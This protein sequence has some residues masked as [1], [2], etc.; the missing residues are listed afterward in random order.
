MPITAQGM[1]Q[2]DLDTFLRAI[3]TLQ[4]ELRTDRST[5]KASQRALLV[6]LDADTG[7]TDTDYEATLMIG[8]TGAAWPADPSSAALV[9]SGFTSIDMSQDDLNTFVQAFEDLINELQTDRATQ[10]LSWTALVQK[11]DADGGI[12]STDYEAKYG[13]GGSVKPWPAN[14]A[15]SAIDASLVAAQGI[16]QPTLY[17]VLAAVETL[18]NELRTDRTTQGLSYD[19]LLAYLDADGTV[20][21]TDYAAVLAI[22]GSGDAW[23]ANPSASALDLSA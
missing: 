15:A 18:S 4:N 6:K 23:P 16:N 9:V 13:L 17:T 20:N 1:G 22:G 12:T 21:D 7:V 14:P 10:T 3:A 11:L 2:P 8:G 5:S 19:G